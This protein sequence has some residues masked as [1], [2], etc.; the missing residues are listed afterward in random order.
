MSGLEVYGSANLPGINSYNIESK[1]VTD[2][3]VL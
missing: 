3:V 2:I 1:T